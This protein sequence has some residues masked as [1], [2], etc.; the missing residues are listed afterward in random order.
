MVVNN[1]VII[2]D[3]LCAAFQSRWP[4]LYFAIFYVVTVVI[5]LNMLLAFI[6]ESFSVQKARREGARQYFGRK[7][8]LRLDRLQR[9]LL[10]LRRAQAVRTLGNGVQGLSPEKAGLLA[11]R[12]ADAATQLY[13][14]SEM[15]PT[16]V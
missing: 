8:L 15:Q 4:R 2:C 11:E 12:I 16:T 7:A 5:V 1:W 13:G 10:K 9:L 6:I 14:V 3:G